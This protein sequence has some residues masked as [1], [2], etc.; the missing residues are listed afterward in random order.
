MIP[1]EVADEVTRP[2]RPC[3]STQPRDL[4]CKL[5]TRH[6]RGFPEFPRGAIQLVSET[7]DHLLVPIFPLARTLQLLGQPR[8]L[9]DELPPPVGLVGSA[10]RDRERLDW[11]A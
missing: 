2:A 3:S 10:W 1:C 6:E 4:V 11:L 8:V 7:G 9:M 5:T